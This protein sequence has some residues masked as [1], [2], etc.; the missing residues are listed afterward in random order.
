M[1]LKNS[2]PNGIASTPKH[3]IV[4][5]MSVGLAVNISSNTTT[6]LVYD[7][8]FLD[9]HRAYN[10]ITGQYKVP[11][12]G[13]YSVSAGMYAGNTTGIGLYVNGVDTRYIALAITSS[14]L[15]AG[16]ILVSLKANDLID[17]RSD[18][19]TTMIGN[20]VYTNFLSVHRLIGYSPEVTF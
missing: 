8:V 1:S 17:I 9:T 18:A 19:N 6:P 13:Y 4:V 15:R 16:T 5:A 3:L 12:D 7:T 11:I 10:T 14:E 20:S 2:S